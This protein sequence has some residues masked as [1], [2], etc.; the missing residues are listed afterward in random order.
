[1][2]DSLKTGHD[3]VRLGV[4]GEEIARLRRDVAGLS[5]ALEL[6]SGPGQA[7]MSWAVRVE[8]LGLFQVFTAGAVVPGSAWQSKKARDLLKILVSRRGRPA[9]REELIELLWPDDDSA[10][11]PNRLSVLLC[12]LRSVL[13][14]AAL[15]ADRST[16]R[17][18]PEVVHTDVDD[19][20]TVAVAALEA[21]RSRRP[22]GPALL[23]AAEAAYTGEFCAEDAYAPWA[24]HLREELRTLHLAVVRALAAVC[25]SEGQVDAAVRWLLALL[26]D[27]L[28]DES[29]HLELVET[30]DAAG[31]YGD[32]RR[33]YRVYTERMAEISVHPAPYP[34]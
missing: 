12:T 27:D 28:Y 26:R 23:V 3:R 1:M 22:D 15:V 6:L 13:D 24:S 16:V 11:A 2:E 31:R 5:A 10:K 19:F 29:A 34:C 18:D 21:W 14:P 9:T 32:A 25:R 4:L 33:R 8:A 20:T 30:L 17:L 7:G